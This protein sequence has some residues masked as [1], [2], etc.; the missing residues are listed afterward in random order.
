MPTR[1]HNKYLD[2]HRQEHERA[3]RPT[4]NRKDIS[5]EVLRAKAYPIDQLLEFRQ[6]KVCCLWHNETQPSL[7]YYT[8]TNTVYCFGC[9]KHGDAIDIY[10]A[11][12][13]CGFVDAVKALNK[14]V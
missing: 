6:N 12:N 7:H 1:F 10:R 11:I 14:L 13:S 2:H 3:N 4:P 5:D 9:G 8:K